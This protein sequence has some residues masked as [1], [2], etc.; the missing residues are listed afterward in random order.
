MIERHVVEIRKEMNEK[1]LQDDE[2]RKQ[3]VHY[4]PQVYT[5]G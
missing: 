1:R 5:K 3:Y 4:A 2:Q